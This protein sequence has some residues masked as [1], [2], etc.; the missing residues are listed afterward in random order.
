VPAG[1]PPAEQRPS[2]CSARSQR[3][4]VESLEAIEES[5]EIEREAAVR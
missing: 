5:V 1:R 2:D 3:A 4:Q